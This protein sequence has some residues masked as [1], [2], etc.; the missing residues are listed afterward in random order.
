MTS[1]PQSPGLRPPKQARSQASLDR[2]L[3]ATERLLHVQ[4]FDALVLTD[5]LGAARVSTGAFY[6]RFESKNAILPL[7]LQR[8]DARA[9]TI[10]DRVLDARRWAGRD[11]VRRVRT[12]IRFQVTMTRRNHGLMRALTLLVR[13][14]PELLTPARLAWR[15]QLQ[16]RVVKLLLADRAAVDHPDP[17]EAIRFLLMLVNSACRD[18]ILTPSI[19]P[20]GPAEWDDR[21]LA[22]ELADL[23]LMKLC[24]TLAR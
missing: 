12:L 20:F 1:P 5:I 11:L 10:A 7:L 19:S 14:Q 22:N 9:E 2:I 13:A 23:V 24:S 6:T 4:Q 8:Y 21:T 15:T 18:A 17:E 16:S 3:N